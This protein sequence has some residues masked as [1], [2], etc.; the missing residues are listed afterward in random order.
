MRDRYALDDG[1]DW[2]ASVVL[3]LAARLNPTWMPVPADATIPAGT[4]VR[5]EYQEYAHRAQEWTAKEDRTP[6]MWQSGV[7]YLVPSG[8]ALEFP[9]DPR[10]ESA[11]RAIYAADQQDGDEQC[12]DTD[13]D[14]IR[15]TYVR[16][17][18]AAAEALGVTL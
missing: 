8:T 2:C 17:A 11:A 18:K 15:D 12:W 14:A 13:T 9:L 6:A 4:L 10:I 3:D 16:L 5:V 7:V 1:W